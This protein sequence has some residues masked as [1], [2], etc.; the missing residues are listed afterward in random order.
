MARTFIVGDVHGMDLE[1]AELW[2]ALAPRRGDRFVSVG[3]LVD[4]G[5]ASAEVLAFLRRRR[6][7]GFEILLVTGNH[8]DNHRKSGRRKAQGKPLSAADEQRLAL[9]D[10]ED[11]AFLAEGRPWLELPEHEALVVH[12]GITPL[13]AELP[14]D[15]R[16]V[17]ELQRVRHVRRRAL[18]RVTVTFELESDEVPTLEE[19]IE[20][21]EPVS[22]NVG[23]VLPAGSYLHLGQHGPDDPFWAEVYDGRFGHVYFGHSPFVRAEPRRWEHATCLDTGCVLGGWLTAAILEVGQEPRFVSVE[24]QRVGWSASEA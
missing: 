11:R 15:R 1:L 18:R 17:E 16:G 24:A 23:R 13:L 19:V 4:K 2:E 10:D 9:L 20:R 3:D 12:G 21:G 8:E 5:P 22:T 6:A 14:T 7:E